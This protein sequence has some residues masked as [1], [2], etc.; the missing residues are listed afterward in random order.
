MNLIKKV[1]NYLNV[2]KRISDQNKT[3]RLLSE[4]YNKL[5]KRHTELS[6]KFVDRG[7]QLQNIQEEHLKLFNRV[8]DGVASTVGL[9]LIGRGGK[10]MSGHICIAVNVKGVDICEMYKIPEGEDDQYYLDVIR[11]LCMYTRT[12]I[13]APYGMKNSFFNGR[14]RDGY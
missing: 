4:E 3:L 2:F 6:K 7:Y 12:K 13:D 1:F 11:K 14:Y 5:E 9:D 10:K 8:K